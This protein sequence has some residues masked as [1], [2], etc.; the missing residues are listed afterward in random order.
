MIQSGEKVVSVSYSHFS[1]RKTLFLET[2]ILLF[3]SSATTNICFVSCIH[4]M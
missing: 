4:K 2:K 3:T 1:K